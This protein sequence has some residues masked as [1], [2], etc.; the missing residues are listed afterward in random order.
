MQYFIPLRFREWL[1]WFCCVSGNE[2]EIKPTQNVKRVEDR[3]E[4]ER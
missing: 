3:S 2:S 1:V 4:R